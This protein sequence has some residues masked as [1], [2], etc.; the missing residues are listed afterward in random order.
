MPLEEPLSMSAALTMSMGTTDL[1]E[2]LIGAFTGHA[3]FTGKGGETRETVE[4]VEVPESLPVDLRAKLSVCVI[5]LRYKLPEVSVSV[6][7]YSY[8]KLSEFILKFIL[9]YAEH[10]YT[11]VIYS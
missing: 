4:V 3:S 8:S 6:I 10:S 7:Y 1:L 11:I 5:H 9:F 2:P